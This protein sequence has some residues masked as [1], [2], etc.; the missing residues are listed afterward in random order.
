MNRK[1]WKVVTCVAPR[2][3]SSSSCCGHDLQWL[4]SFYNCH[5]YIY[6][7]IYN[8]YIDFRIRHFYWRPYIRFVKMIGNI[9]M[10]VAVQLF[11]SFR[12][13]TFHSS[14][15]TILHCF[16]ANKTVATTQAVR[17][18]QYTA[19]FTPKAL[20]TPYP[21]PI[22]CSLSLY[23]STSPCHKSCGVQAHF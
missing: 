15:Y 23:K 5:L 4:Q 21:K 7:Y 20:R 13:A 16:L 8:I 10:L 18:W 14:V 3:S 11:H 12:E 1:H 9:P 19:S 6:I 17:V 2:I 22:K